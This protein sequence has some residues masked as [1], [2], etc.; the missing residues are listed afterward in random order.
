MYD[1]SS[2]VIAKIIAI[3]A[4]ELQIEVGGVLGQLRINNS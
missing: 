1:L 4:V 3:L 2:E